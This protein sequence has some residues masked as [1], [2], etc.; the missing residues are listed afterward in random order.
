MFILF[1]LPGFYADCQSL[2][3][4]FDELPLHLKLNVAADLVQVI[5]SHEITFHEIYT[6]PK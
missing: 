3:Q 2:V 5:P 1:Q 4:A 6:V